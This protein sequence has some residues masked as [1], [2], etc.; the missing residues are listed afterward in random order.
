ML[1]FGLS[2]PQ[3]AIRGAG[4]GPALWDPEEL[5]AALALWL[6]ASDAATVTLSGSNVSQWE[7]KS[8]NARDFSQGVAGTQPA[9]AL[10]SINGLNTISF[11]GTNDALARSVESWAYSYPV[12]VFAV[13]KATAFN[14]SYNGL[15]GFYTASDAS[16]AGF[17][18][19]I[20]S[21]G[22]SAIYATDTSNGQPNYDG[23]G[24]LTYL[25]NTGYIFGATIG[26]DDF[27]S[28][29]DGSPDGSA[30]GTWTLRNNV[31][32]GE[33]NVGSDPRFSRFTEWEI[34]E[35]VISTGGAISVPNRQRMEGYLAWKWGLE[36]SLPAG[37]PYENAPP[38]VSG[39]LPPGLNFNN[40][41][42]SMYLGLRS[43][44]GL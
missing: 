31:G 20:K 7:D 5:G 27:T 23:T 44:G 13:F 3:L 41:A 11:D 25:I 36:G 8:G 34:A 29:G 22:K 26:D 6:D 15:F 24:A 33:V 38:L 18:A 37:H 4:G 35:I 16:A 9:Y 12:N 43:V 40:P 17:G 2:I 10:A 30:T 21:N 14:A 1:G 42:N 39:A 28:F 32:T 19:F